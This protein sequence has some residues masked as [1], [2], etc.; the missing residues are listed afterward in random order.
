MLPKQALASI[1]K[2]GPHVGDEVSVNVTSNNKGGMRHG[3]ILRS[4]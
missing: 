1:E 4:R 2:H 3:V